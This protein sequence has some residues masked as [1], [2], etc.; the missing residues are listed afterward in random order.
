MRDLWARS[1]ERVQQVHHAISPASPGLSFATLN[2]VSSLPR[3]VS[4][5][6]ER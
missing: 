1:W 6:G 3:Q 5:S 2:S 4:Y